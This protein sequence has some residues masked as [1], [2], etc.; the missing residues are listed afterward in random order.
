MELFRLDC[1]KIR[2]ID[3]DNEYKNTKDGSRLAGKKYNRYQFDG[4]AFAVESTDEFNELWAT[5]KLFSVTLKESEE[6]VDGNVVKRLALV[7]V[8]SK[9][10]KLEDAR[11][12]AEIQ[13]ITPETFKDVRIADPESIPLQ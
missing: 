13:S 12:D 9:T 3:K 11:F 1:K 2:L 4:I 10:D 5:G 8:I 6:T 7:N